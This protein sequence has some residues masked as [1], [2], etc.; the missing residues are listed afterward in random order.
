[1]EE[2]PARKRRARKR[3]TEKEQPPEG[4]AAAEQEAPAETAP[5]EPPPAEAAEQEAAGKQP[6][7]KPVSVFALAHFYITGVFGPLAYQRMGLHADDL[8]GEVVRDLSQAKAAVDIVSA[9][10]EQVLPTLEGDAKRDLMN[11]VTNL[12]MNYAR[13]ARGGEESGG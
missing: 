13:Q 1:M 7:P 4:A 2:K 5:E 6:P 8:T 3:K 12:R 10:A 11:F 9:M